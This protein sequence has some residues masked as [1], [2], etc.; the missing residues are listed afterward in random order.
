MLDRARG[1]KVEAPH[2]TSSEEDLMETTEK[3]V[4]RRFYELLNAGAPEQF[5]EV[6][7]PDLKGHAGAGADLADLKN[8]VASFIQPFPDPRHRPHPAA[9]PSPSRPNTRSTERPGGTT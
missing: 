9:S 3:E 1:W 6:C 4:V 5:D 7:S 8:S 2:Q